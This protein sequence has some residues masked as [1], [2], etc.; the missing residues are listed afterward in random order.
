MPREGYRPRFRNQRPSPTFGSFISGELRL[1]GPRVQLRDHLSTRPLPIKRLATGIMDAHALLSAIS[2]CDGLRSLP[3]R[4]LLTFTRL[5]SMALPYIRHSTANVSNPPASLPS[6]VVRLLSTAVEC[7]PEA[8]QH[9]WNVFKSVTWTSSSISPEVD[10]VELF[11]RAGQEHGM[12]YGDLFPPT[13]VCLN[14]A[15]SGYR[16]TLSEP[17]VYEAT[18]FTLRHGTLPIHSTSTYCRKC[19]TRYHPS[20]HVR[21]GVGM[22]TFYQGVPDVVQAADHYFLETALLELFAACK[23]FGWLSSM[24]CARIY[25]LALA[26]PRAYVANNK[27]AFATTFHDEEGRHRCHSS[28]PLRPADVLNGFFVYSLLL[29]H[30]ERGSF[31]ILPHDYDHKDR[32]DVALVVRNKEMEGIG[33]E[34]YPHACDLCFIVVDGDEGQKLKIQAAVCDG[35]T[36]GHPCCT[37]HDCKVPLETNRC[38]YCPMHSTTYDKK[39]AVE[40]CPS[41]RSSGHHTCV[42]AEHRKLESAYFKPTSALFQLRRKLNKAGISVPHDS[43]TPDESIDSTLIAE[44]DGKAEEGNRRLKT[45]FARRRTHNEQLI[46]RPC[47]VILSRATFF[48]SEAVSAVHDFAK[49]VFPT[50][51]STPEY[52]VFDNNCKLQ[53]HQEVIKDRHFANTGLPVDIFHFNSKHKETDL[54]CQQHCNPAAFPELIQNGKWRF[55]TS[56]CEQTNVWLGGFQAILRDM[57]VHRY[58]FYLDEMIKRR[59]RYVI[60]ELERKGH[61]PCYERT[62]FI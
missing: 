15:C 25:N 18:L 5:T 22:R 51:A 36:I 33:Q 24:N 17:V 32:I 3:F 6:R 40:E 26:N 44:C 11:N 50:Q 38:R 19:L 59:N 16:S 23:T 47:G 41:D 20:Y 28:T 34:A 39:C 55:N 48:G 45:N 31:L 14:T 56:I 10:E 52:F 42:D 58:N 1:P 49:A 12:A 61:V 13:R 4:S 57:G 21:A 54:Y 43:V 8:V 9:C 35:N 27:R 29:H 53:A 7:S 62:Y 46:M 60:S 37:V 2:N 30:A